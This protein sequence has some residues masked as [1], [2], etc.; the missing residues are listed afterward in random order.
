MKKCFWMALLPLVF[1]AATYQS[2]YVSQNWKFDSSAIQDQLSPISGAW[3]IMTPEKLKQPVLSQRVKYADYPKVL[4][5]D[6]DYYD[7]E[8]T[9]KIYISSE[10]SDVQAGGLI[11]RYRNLYS[12]Y[13]L[14][15]NTKD[16][17]LTLTRASRG[18][19]K[20]LKRVNEPFSPDRWYELKAIC[21]LNHVKA[22]VDGQ[23]IM[24]VEDEVST[25]GK[26]GLV[27]AGTSR[28]YF[29][30]LQIKSETF[31]VAH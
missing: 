29:N 27:T 13:M 1:L 23:Q 21:Y 7:F 31:E 18:G 30:D 28:V 22:Y 26:V 6:R 19:M 17:R 11:L 12:F 14:F 9:T 24:D 5:R 3:E 25:G 15:L 4:M 20:V 2:R 8:L 10:S 16:H